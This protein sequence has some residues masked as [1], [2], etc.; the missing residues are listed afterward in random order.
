VRNRDLRPQISHRTKF[1]EFSENFEKIVFF[2]L[3]RLSGGR[4]A[5][6]SFSQE[7]IPDNA[8][9]RRKSAKDLGTSDHRVGFQIRRK[10]YV[11][12]QCVE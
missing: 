3:G 8:N 9:Q 6:E 2:L 10:W 11:L 1:G 7:P 5:G 4:L 12:V